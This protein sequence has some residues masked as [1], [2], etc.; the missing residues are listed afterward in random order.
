[1]R[2]AS[3]LAFAAL[4]LAAPALAESN[5]AKV[6]L[7]E[8]SAK[9]AV[10]IRVPV[11]PFTY[12][13]QFSKDGKS[14]FLSRVYLMKV[15]PAAAPGFAWIARTLSPGRYRLD[16]MWQQGR[17]S[18]CLERGTFEV[19]VKPGRIHYVGT[20][21][22]DTVLRSLQDQAAAAGETSQAGTAYYQSH[23]KT[24]IPPLGDRDEAALA[25][26]RAFAEQSMNGSARLVELAP[27]RQTTFGTSA[28]GKAIKICG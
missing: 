1:M 23:G 9:G 17:W 15:K 3:L 28:A 8:R 22:T 12:A 2:I 16:S 24:E 13:L 18:A 27:V 11:Q 10:L 19:E 7:T 4:I 14:G 5:P 20:L 6:R 25:A 21:D 26:A